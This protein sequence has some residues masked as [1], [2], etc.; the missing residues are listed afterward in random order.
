MLQ[1]DR[2]AGGG[3]VGDGAL[4]GSAVGGRRLHRA[5]RFV[6]Y[7][8]QHIPTARKPLSRESES[9]CA[10]PGLPRAAER[11]T[12]PVGGKLMLKGGLQVKVRPSGGGGGGG[13]EAAARLGAG[14]C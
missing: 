9:V 13:G 11:A 2:P 12:M 1:P 5:C 4:L 7:L 8:L 10:A 3:G 14:G 6:R